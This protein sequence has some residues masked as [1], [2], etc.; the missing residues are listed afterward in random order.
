MASPL[1]QSRIHSDL[2]L[3]SSLNRQSSFAAN[4]V[5]TSYQVNDFIAFI[6]IF[7]FS[8]FSLDPWYE[9]IL[10]P[11]ISSEMKDILDISK[12][13]HELLHEVNALKEQISALNNSIQA[14]TPSN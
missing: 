8:V 1:L 10:S 3:F 2:A 6:T 7:L 13:P 5:T 14:E 9:N 11:Q 4:I 12:L